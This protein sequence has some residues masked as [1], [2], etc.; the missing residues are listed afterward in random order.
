MLEYSQCVKIF[1]AGICQ[2]EVIAAWS[3]ISSLYSLEF[4][5]TLCNTIL[6]NEL[7]G[8]KLCCCKY[9]VS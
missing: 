4:P 6:K 5:T 2:K 8:L 3:F 7:F 9:V 1:W